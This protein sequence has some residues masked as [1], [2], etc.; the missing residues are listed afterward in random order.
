MA[1]LRSAM[2]R[3]SPPRPTGTS[4]P[5]PLGQRESVDQ[6]HTAGTAVERGE[7]VMRSSRWVHSGAMSAASKSA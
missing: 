5:G 2:A 1:G 3:R 7:P 6:R 4:C